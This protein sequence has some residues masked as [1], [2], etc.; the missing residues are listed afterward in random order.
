MNPTEA[1][2]PHAP[3]PAGH[4]ES[5]YLKASHPSE[6]LAVWIRYTVQKRPGDEAKGSLWFTLFDGSAAAPRASK[7]TLPG[8]SVGEGDW[9]RM[10]QSR[11]GEGA[12]SGS[13]RSE[14]SEAAWELRFHGAEAPL[15]HLPHER[16]YETRLPRTKT[17]SPLPAGRF[18]G[19]LVVDGQELT[20]RNWPGVVGHNWGAEHAERWIWLHG[21][22]FEEERDDSWLDVAIGRVR[23]GP[24]TT[25]WIASGAVS[26]RGR[27]FRLGG[28]G[29][30]ARVSEATERCDFALSGA[31]VKLRGAVSADLKDCVGWLYA[32]PD[33]S[34]HQVT[35][36]SIADLKLALEPAGLPSHELHL[37][38]GAAYEL[39]RRERDPR[40]ETQPFP[41]D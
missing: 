27:R 16:M 35:N 12:A 2:F 3:A 26:L 9:I 39:G 10:G 37:A 20:L 25:P 17:C 6:P 22:G 19:L 15:L 38:G 7:V 14:R 31:G 28:L 29:R 1:R 21:L 24:L 5:F 4:Y 30:R 34:Q 33:G 23:I 11:F 40:V 32:D 41:D 36:C 18:E 8:P 13:A